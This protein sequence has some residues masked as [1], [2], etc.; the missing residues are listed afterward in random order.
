VGEAPGSRRWRRV[1]EGGWRRRVKVMPV[2]WL[3]EPR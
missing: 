2:V 1:E 3:C